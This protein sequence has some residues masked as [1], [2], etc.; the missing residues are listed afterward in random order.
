MKPY[1]KTTLCFVLKSRTLSIAGVGTIRQ[2]HENSGI[3]IMAYSNG[4]PQFNGFPSGYPD[5]K[6]FKFTQTILQD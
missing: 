5:P 6:K 4:I 1:S 2:M 3:H